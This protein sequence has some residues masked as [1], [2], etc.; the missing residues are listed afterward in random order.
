VALT[1]H[2]YKQTAVTGDNEARNFMSVQWLA[3]IEL[4]HGE[5]NPYGSMKLQHLILFIGK[6]YT[7]LLFNSCRGTICW[8]LPTIRLHVHTANKT[9]D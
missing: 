2:D 4:L 9:E 1:N 7:S 8:I 5:W 3:W 6:I